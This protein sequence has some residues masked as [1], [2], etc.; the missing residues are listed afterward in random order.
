VKRL[1]LGGDRIEVGVEEKEITTREWYDFIGGVADV[2]PAIHLGGE[3]AT[4][5]LLAMLALSPSTRV[6]DIGCGSGHTACMTAKTYGSR[7]T[8]DR[9]LRGHGGPG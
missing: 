3:E 9:H 2:I 1:R 6:L 8:R 4:R 7:V 5:D